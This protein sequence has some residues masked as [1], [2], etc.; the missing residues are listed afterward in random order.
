MASDHSSLRIP[1]ILKWDSNS[2]TA[3]FSLDGISWV[4]QP[5]EEIF[6]LELNVLSAGYGLAI[7]FGGVNGP[8]SLTWR[9]GRY[10]E[11]PCKPFKGGFTLDLLQPPFPPPGG[12]QIEII[13]DQY[14][15]QQGGSTV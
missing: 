4:V 6:Y 9:E 11:W 10:F 8:P 15:D 5:G 13:I 3:P 14:G 12:V 2:G 1:R 7:R